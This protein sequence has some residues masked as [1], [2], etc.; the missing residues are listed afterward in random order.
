M[1]L[2]LK[3]DLHNKTGNAKWCKWKQYKLY[4]NGQTWSELVK[5]NGAAEFDKYTDSLDCH[6]GL[7][8][9]EKL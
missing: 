3:D 9:N 8:L 2:A 1:G 7:A 5:Q 6:T 4:K